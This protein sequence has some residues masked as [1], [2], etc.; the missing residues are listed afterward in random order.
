MHGLLP[1]DE[2]ILGDVL[3]IDDRGLELAEQFL[4]ERR[5]NDTLA[6]LPHPDIDRALTALS[7]V[8]SLTKRGG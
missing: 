1:G 6:C 7:T 3:E 4:H 2:R 5:Y 8:R